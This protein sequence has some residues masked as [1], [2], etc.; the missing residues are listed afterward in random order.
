MMEIRITGIGSVSA[1]GTLAGAITPASVSPSAITA[2]PAGDGS[3]AC[4]VPPFRPADVVPGLKTRRLDR[5]SVW[6]LVA[7]SLAV[8]D[9][10]IDLDALDRARAA[11]VFGTG[12]GCLELTEAFFR[13]AA[14]HGWAQTDPILFPETLGNAPA[15]HIARHFGIRGP[16]LTV[17]SK[18]SAGECALSQGVSLLRNGQADTALVLAG[19]ALTQ[20]A[21]KWYEAAGLLAQGFVPAE[22][23]AALVLES[24]ASSKVYARVRFGAG[25]AAAVPPDPVAHG[26]RDSGGLLRLAIALGSAA[27]P[28]S[29][30]VRSLRLEVPA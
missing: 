5:L 29:F 1:Y 27:R 7:A 12:L 28:S 9:S 17:S 15:G 19:D 22:G 2:W 20:G 6:S 10:E 30:D 13:S 18:G 4:L 21:Y 26:I 11:V 3:R 16:N 23:V 24:S 8:R 25:S 14:D